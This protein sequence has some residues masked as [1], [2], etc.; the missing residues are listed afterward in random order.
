MEDQVRDHIIGGQTDQLGAGR[1]SSVSLEP[2]SWQDRVGAKLDWST[3]ISTLSQRS[4]P[5][6]L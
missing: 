3:K 2:R 1:L 6:L 5:T 4:A